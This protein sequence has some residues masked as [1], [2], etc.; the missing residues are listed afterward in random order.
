[1]GKW[2]ILLIVAA[3]S[4]GSE[5]YGYWVK[6]A[7]DPYVTGQVIA[8]TAAQKLIEDQHN[9]RLDAIRKKQQ[10]IAKYNETMSTI[11]TLYKFSMANINGWGY[12]S[13]TYAQIAETTA[14]I[15]QRLPK[16]IKGLN[17]FP[18]KNELLCT[19]ELI[20][21]MTRTMSCVA[22]FTDIVN[23]GKVKIPIKNTTNLPTNGISTGGKGDGLNLLDHYTRYRLANSILSDLDR[24]NYQ[25]WAICYMCDYYH[26][27]HG[28]IEAIDPEGWV[29]YVTGKNIVNNIINEWKG[30]AS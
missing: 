20:S 27:M 5:G 16:A 23:N 14:Q 7:I 28:L 6:L 25:L 18:I 30:L 10:M 9:A 3:L 21:I 29:N 24:I 13:A 22:T 2:K 1:M 19:N 15:F 12:E 8:N 11:K 17:K 4:I 26:G